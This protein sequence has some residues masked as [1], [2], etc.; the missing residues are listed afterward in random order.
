MQLSADELRK[1]SRRNHV[2][3][4]YDRVHKNC[5]IN[6]MSDVSEIAKG[7][8]T[9]SRDLEEVLIG[10]QPLI[11]DYEALGMY[12]DFK[13]D[14]HCDC[15]EQCGSDEDNSSFD[16]DEINDRRLSHMNEPI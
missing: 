9:M 10:P 7:L 3:E 11:E 4:Y 16:S 5:L 13:S 6:A 1:L 15:Y 14:V 8:D 2:P 12:D